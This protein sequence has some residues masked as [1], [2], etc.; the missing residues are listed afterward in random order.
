MYD[1][2]AYC[3]VRDIVIADFLSWVRV[4]VSAASDRVQTIHTHQLE[5]QNV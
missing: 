5:E 2:L 3:H 1:V 4:Q